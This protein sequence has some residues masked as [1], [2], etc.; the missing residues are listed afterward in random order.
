M[1]ELRWYGHTCFRIKAREATIFLDPVDR[2]TGFSLG[3]QS[4]DIVTLSG[5]P[6]GGNLGAIRP[7]FQ[8]IGGPG[9]YE[10]HEVFVTGGRTYQD[11]QQGAT[12]G[13]NTTYV[14]DVEGLKIGHLGN[15]GHPLTDAQSEALEGVDIL[16]APVGGA[17][18]LTTDQAVEL[19][20]TL[21]PKVVIPMRY[22]TSRGDTALGDVADF[23]KKLGVDTPEVEDKL[24]VKP[25][26]LGETMR[27]VVLNPDGEA[28]KR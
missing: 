7:E 23:S 12:L 10:M 6:Q 5:D 4:A 14:I 28:G 26:D 11:D 20:T 2:S 8:V 27:L 19:V 24:T 22:A 21:A 13:Y 25:S 3:K 18:S 17:G 15:L 16:L 1:A 9:E